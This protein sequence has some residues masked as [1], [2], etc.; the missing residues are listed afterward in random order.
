MFLGWSVV[1]AIVSKVSSAVEPVRFVPSRVVGV[2]YV[3]A[4]D[5]EDGFGS[6]SRWGNEVYR[7]REDMR[8][9]GRKKERKT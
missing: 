2:R 3:E 4:G 9:M 6:W 1:A 7:C 5:L 8:E